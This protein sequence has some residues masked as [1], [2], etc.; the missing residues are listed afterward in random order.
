[1]PPP[2][3]TLAG[4]FAGLEQIAQGVQQIDDTVSV[5]QARP[6][7]INLPAVWFWLD[8][9]QMAPADTHVDEDTVHVRAIVGVR[10]G[11]DRDQAQR[12]FALADTVRGVL[13][14]ALKNKNGPLGGAAARRIG[15]TPGEHEF[16]AVPVLAIEFPI[17]VHLQS[18]HAPQ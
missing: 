3:S 5:Y 7:Q 1:M 17:R 4:L 10:H 16:N 9:G 2:V 13:D 11:D 15:M 12:L 18:A 14:S 8:P 6:H